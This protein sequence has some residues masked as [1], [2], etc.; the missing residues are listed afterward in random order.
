MMM[1]PKSMGACP[2]HSDLQSLYS[3]KKTHLTPRKIKQNKNRLHKVLWW[4]IQKAWVRARVIQTRKACIVKKKTHLTP[5]KIK[6]NKQNDKVFFVLVKFDE[7][8]SDEFVKLL[9]N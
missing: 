8:I 1:Y 7:F 2:C 5:R 4:C 6:Q 9:W 3:E